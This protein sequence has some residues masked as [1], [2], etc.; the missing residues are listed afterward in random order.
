[1]SLTLQL[2]ALRATLASA[3]QQIDAMLGATAAPAGECAHPMNRRTNLSTMGEPR[4]GCR[5]CGV[6]VE[7]QPVPAG[8]D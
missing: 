1:M 8:G 3:V 7:E 2:K 4:F 6:V 5:D